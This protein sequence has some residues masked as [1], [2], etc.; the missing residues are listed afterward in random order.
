MNLLDL[1]PQ[2]LERYFAERGEK[3]FRARQVS[4]WLHQRLATDI[5]AGRKSRVSAKNLTTSNPRLA[6]CAMSSRISPNA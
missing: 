5:G 4:R 1:D 3:P 6:I 2:G